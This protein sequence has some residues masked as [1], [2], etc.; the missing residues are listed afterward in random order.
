MPL[1]KRF[2]YI[3]EILYPHWENVLL[4]GILFPLVST[5]VYLLWYHK[6]ALWFYGKKLDQRKE[7][8][9]KRNEVEKAQLLSIDEADRLRARHARELARLESKFKDASDRNQVLEDAAA[10]SANQLIR[11]QEKV[12][13]LVASDFPVPRGNTERNEA[14]RGMLMGRLW[15]LYFNPNSGGRKKM[16]F[17]RDGELL[18]GGNQNENRWSTTDGVLR[19][20]DQNG[21]LFSSFG[22]DANRRTFIMIDEESP[23]AIKGQFMSSE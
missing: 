9:D 22:Y 4:Q 23:K 11:L 15:T 10:A 14:L 16:L 3:D 5:V 2:G 8:L 21:N 12:N 6:P 19:F 13:D 1:P 17:G 18:E 7:L 20:H